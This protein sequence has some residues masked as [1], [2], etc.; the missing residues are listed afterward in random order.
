MGKQITLDCSGLMCPMPV[1]KTAKTIKTMEI[2]DILEMIST[3]AGS[4][5]D[6]QAW[7]N[8]TKHELLESHDEGG[9]FRFLI[10]KTH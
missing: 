4:M 1:V 5:P 8:Q 6:M 2:G 9:K 10:K 3:D 7:A